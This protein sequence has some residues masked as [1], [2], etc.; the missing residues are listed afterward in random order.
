MTSKQS[1]RELVREAIDY[2]GSWEYD[3]IRGWRQ[4]AEDAIS[5][6][7]TTDRQ[8]TREAIDYAIETLV[9]YQAMS[10]PDCTCEPGQEKPCD[11]CRVASAI[12]G[13]RGA[14]EP[15]ETTDVPC[16]R[17]H[18]SQRMCEGLAKAGS[19]PRC[20]DHC[21]HSAVEPRGETFESLVEKRL[22]EARE[23]YGPSAKN[24]TYLS[25][26]SAQHVRDFIQRL[27]DLL[28]S[29]RAQTRAGIRN[30]APDEGPPPEPDIGDRVS[31]K[32]DPET[33]GSVEHIS[34]PYFG[35]VTVKWDKPDPDELTSL[36][37]KDLVFCS[38]VEP[39]GLRYRHDWEALPGPSYRCKRCS[40]T[41]IDAHTALLCV[42]EPE[43]ASGEQKNTPCGRDVDG[44]LHGCTL[45]ISH[46]GACQVVVPFGG[47]K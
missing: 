2:I 25:R 13:L 20:C 15:R 42:V 1:L 24:V 23:I 6:D 32:S 8:P 43:K 27:A 39:C 37:V 40:T 36:S 22:K 45:P 4:R 14:V 31:L 26:V 16:R 41:C 9:R 29:Q 35:W 38:S 17:C 5:A 19:I 18:T 34:R 21:D 33:T 10:D 46:K 30:A 7:E 11:G 12:E 47:F 3:D 44:F 28:E